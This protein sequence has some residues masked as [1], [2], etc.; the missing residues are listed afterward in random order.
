M[1]TLTD[2]SS[3]ASPDTPVALVLPGVGYT[4]QAPLLYWSVGIL[5]AGGWRVITA[6][7]TDKDS[8]FETP[9]MLI[10]H[11]LDAA[12]TEAG[13]QLDL[14]VAKSLGTLALPYAVTRGIPGIWLT[15]LLNRSAVAEAVSLADARHLAVGGTRDRHW[16]PDAITGTRATL[17]E[18]P[19][20]N[21]SLRLA[22][23]R[24]SLAVQS[25]IF[26]QVAMHIS[27]LEK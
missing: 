1:A 24:S 3:E 2:L 9:E 10:E 8:E 26:E 25:T 21:H 13:S 20:A 12:T 18:I 22:D 4:V 15:P 27:R 14:I 23:W 17:L 7:W 6:D 5:L 16:I 11:T 19:D